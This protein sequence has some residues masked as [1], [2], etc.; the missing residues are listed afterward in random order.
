MAA[1]AAADKDG[2]F[3]T[4]AAGGTIVTMTEDVADGTGKVQL[5]KAKLKDFSDGNYK[6][7]LTVS[8]TPTTEEVSPAP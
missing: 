3:T 1:G 4:V 5:D 7:K 8:I 2:L 6:G